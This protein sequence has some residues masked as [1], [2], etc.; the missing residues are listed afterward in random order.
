MFGELKKWAEEYE[1]I[2]GAHVPDGFVRFLANRLG[3]TLPDHKD[4]LNIY[5][6]GKACRIRILGQAG[7]VINYQYDNGE[8]GACTIDQMKKWAKPASVAS[9]VDYSKFGE[10]SELASQLGGW[11]G[12]SKLNPGSIGD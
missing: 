4:W 6:D 7:H 3:E 5:K 1:Q 11:N 12:S 2:G 9:A 8:Y 10:A